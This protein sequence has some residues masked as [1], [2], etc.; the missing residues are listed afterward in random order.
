V[1]L[2]NNGKLVVIDRFMHYTTYGFLVFPDYA[3]RARIAQWHSTGLWA[4]WLGVQVPIGVRNFSLHCHIQ[5]SSGAH[6]ASYPMCIGGSFPGWDVKLT[7]HLHLVLRSRMHGAI[8]PL[9][10]YAFMVW[11]SVKAQG[12]FYLTFYFTFIFACSGPKD[13]LVS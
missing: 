7:T 4:G 3:S 5:T 6:P 13:A 1:W 8:P 9:L 10:Q 2:P 11:C 12:H